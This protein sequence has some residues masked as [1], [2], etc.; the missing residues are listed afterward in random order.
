MF[1]DTLPDYP[2]PAPVARQG[3]RMFGASQAGVLADPT[4]ASARGRSQLAGETT[5]VHAN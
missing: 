1:D 3:N 5:R 2:S 4:L